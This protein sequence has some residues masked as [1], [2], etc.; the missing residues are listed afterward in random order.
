MSPVHHDHRISQQTFHKGQ[1]QVSS[2][3]P[4]RSG[5]DLPANYL[6]V[7]LPLRTHQSS[8][9]HYPYTKKVHL[10]VQLHPNQHV[11][12]DLTMAANRP[13]GNLSALITSLIS[14]HFFLPPV[15]QH[16]NKKCS[17]SLTKS[18]IMLLYSLILQTKKQAYNKN[19]SNTT[20]FKN[21]KTAERS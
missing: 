9:D 18:L 15:S 16:Q 14:F 3:D 11:Q 20:Y 7:Q 2:K 13:S 10:V 12:N 17:N 19:F 21:H 8:V 5:F 1:N 6:P 4:T